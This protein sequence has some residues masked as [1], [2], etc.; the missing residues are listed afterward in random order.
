[1]VSVEIGRINK[2]VFNPLKTL[3][4]IKNIDSVITLIF[5]FNVTVED[6]VQTN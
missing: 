6:A 1:M 4:V 2:T 3:S 5:V